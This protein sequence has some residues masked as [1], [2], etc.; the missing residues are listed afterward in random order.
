[1]REYLIDGMG[2]EGGIV[3][4]VGSGEMKELLCRKKEGEMDRG[5]MVRM[6]GVIGGGEGGSG[7]RLKGI[8]VRGCELV[9]VGLYERGKIE[10]KGMREGEVEMVVKVV[11][12]VKGDEIYVGGELGEGDGSEGVCREG[13]FGGMDEE[14]NG[15][16]EWV[17]EWGMWM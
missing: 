1:M 11:G 16:G 7:C 12:E 5:E 10:K 15:G 4:K 3:V 8:G 6:K 2:E 14:K 17:K 9:E 13:V